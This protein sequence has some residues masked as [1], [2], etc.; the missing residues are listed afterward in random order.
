MGRV[1]GVCV[2]VFAIIEMVALQSLVGL[3]PAS[4]FSGVLLKVGHDVFDYEPVFNY[5]KCTI[6][7]KAHPGGNSPVVSHLDVLFIVGTTVVTIVVNLNIAVA[8]FTVAFYLA[9]LVKINVP[10]MPTSDRLKEMNET[11]DARQA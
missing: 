1:A 9:R 2:G 5:V 3:I 11:E 10:D 6:L 4:V 7:R 8:S